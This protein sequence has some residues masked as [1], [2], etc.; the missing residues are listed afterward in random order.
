M[1]LKGCALSFVQF[2]EL[3]QTFE[4]LLKKGLRLSVSLTLLHFALETEK[5]K[6]LPR[7]QAL[8]QPPITFFQ[9][10]FIVSI[11]FLFLFLVL[12]ESLLECWGISDDNPAMFV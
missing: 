7:V 8:L 1:A 12:Q 9:P 5:K 10:S 4:K 11:T 3:E 6:F 2:L